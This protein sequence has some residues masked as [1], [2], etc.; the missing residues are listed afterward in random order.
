MKKIA[1][2][3]CTLQLCVVV[4]AAPAAYHV[5][6]KLQLGGEG[7]WD[8]LYADSQARRLYISRGT[9]VMIVDL[10]SGRLAGDLPNTPGV[11][12]IAVAPELGRGFTSNGRANTATL[13]DLKTLRPLGQ[14]KTGAN[15]DAILYDRASRRVVTFNGKS[16]DATVFS[17]TS[18]QVLATIPL[19]GKPEF[20]AADGHG[21]VY[22]NNED[23][24][25]VI[26]IDSRKLVV[27]H[28]WS[29]KPGES[30]S[31][32]ALDA[33]HH[34]VFSVCGNK[35]MTILDLRT[36]KV[37]TL[38]IGQGADGAAFD[39]E[40]RLIFSSNGEG[41]VTVAREVAKGKF[42]VLQTV[43]TQRGARTMAIDLQTHNLYLP[44]ALFGPA[45]EPTAAAPRPRPQA[46]K[47][48][49]MLVVAANQ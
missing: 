27:T 49:F 31:G 18:G 42:E 37:A 8:Y 29:I 39:P 36:G 3:L 25:E 23:T 26:E 5:V 33:R 30:P 2:L 38:P 12:G 28:R 15:P 17:A 14:V 32:L 13:F 6:N 21:K 44:T 22:V 34:H 24:A 46:I 1:L 19:G 45:P 48:S 16:A 20:S 35:L 9:H 47:D 11:H 10:D 43:P 40:T 7:G 41:T 4:C